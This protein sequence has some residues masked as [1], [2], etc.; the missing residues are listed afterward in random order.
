MASSM[1]S[2]PLTRPLGAN[3]RLESCSGG[4]RK[5]GLRDDG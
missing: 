3:P 1:A 2:M 5:I 4:F